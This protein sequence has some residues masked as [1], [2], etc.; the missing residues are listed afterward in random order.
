MVHT[1]SVILVATVEGELDAVALRLADLEASVVE[2]KSTSPRR[3]VVLAAATDEWA[4]EKITATLRSEGLM[5]ASRPDE[6]VRLAR[7]SHVTR[8]VTIAGRVTVAFAWSEHD[9]GG[10]PRVIELGYGGFGN[11][12][13]PT[14]RLV[15][16]ALADRVAR[17]DQVLDVGCGSGVLG[18]CSLALGADRMVGVDLDERAVLAT[19]RH[20]VVNGM[21]SRVEVTAGFLESID[22][23]FDVVVANIA[24]AGI[25]ELADQLVAKVAPGGWIA[26]SG[27]TP[28]QCT[29]VTEFLR[30]LRE[31]G[32][33]VD[34]DW[35]VVVLS[36]T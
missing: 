3:R 18:L 20:A 28:S 32:R 7:W 25:V 4:A 12:Q 17:G 33:R 5:V 35:S 21:G 13:H 9:Q 11:A 1:C 26:V 10:L 19:S 15:I 36:R 23:T 30:P 27:I 8:P 24:R 14:T 29:Q 16:E 31:V 2:V 22:A 34:G 6:G